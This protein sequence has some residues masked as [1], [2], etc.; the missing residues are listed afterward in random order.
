MTN[1]LDTQTTPDTGGLV[2]PSIGDSVSAVTTTAP[3]LSQSPGLV[4]GIA[5]SG[6]DTTGRAQAVARGANA[7]S[8]NNAQTRVA[9]AVGGSNELTSA[10]SWFGNHASAVGS[11]VLQGAKT[12]GSNALKILNAPLSQVQH[13]Y[14]YLHDVEAT[15]G[16]M[17]ATLEG[18]GLAAGA[19]AGL[20]ATGSL[21]GA[22]LGAETA[23]GIEGQVFYKDSW[24][25]TSSSSYVDPHT[26]QQVSLGRDIVS[27]LGSHGVH[28]EQGT[29]PYR[30]TSGIIDGLFDLNTGGTEVLGLTNEARSS[31]GLGGLLNARWGGTAPQTLGDAVNGVGVIDPSEIDRITSQYSGVRRA[32]ADIASKTPEEIIATPYL[33]PFRQ[34][35][36]QLGDAQTVDEVGQVF[37]GVLRTQELAFTDRMPSMSWTRKVFGQ[38]LR[39]QVESMT[40]TTVDQVG[41]HPLQR[42]ASLL[43]PANMAQRLSPLPTAYDDAVHALTMDSFNPASKVDDGTVGIH[44]MLRFT[45]DGPTSASTAWAYHNMPDLEQKVLAYRNISL[46]VLFALSSMRGYM[47]DDLTK[48]P[49]LEGYLRDAFSDPEDQKAMKTAIDNAFGGGMFGKEAWYGVD[50]EGRNLSSIRASEGDAQYGAAIWKNQTGKLAFLDLAEARRAASRMAGAKDVLG[51]LDDFGYHAITQGIF[52]PLVLLTPSYAMHIALAEDIPNGLREGVTAL[53][54]SK[55]AGNVARLGRRIGETEAMDADKTKAISG[56]AWH[57]VTSTMDKMPTTL[58]ADLQRRIE[59]AAVYLE[60][61]GGEAVA[62][63]L[64]SM[65]AY[66]SEVGQ[67]EKTVDLLRRSYFDSPMKSSKN[68]GLIGSTDKQAVPAWQAS[69]KEIANDESGQLAAKELI[70]GA[71]RGENIETATGNARTVLAQYLREHADDNDWAMRANSQVTSATPGFTRPP[72][73]DNYDE[74]AH[75]KLHALRGV[76]RGA[77]K[78]MNAGILAHIAEGTTP[79]R[80]ELDAIPAESRPLVIKARQMV[81]DGTGTVQ[82]IANV[83]FRRI[84]NPM[85]NFGSR[86]A[87]ALNEWDRQWEIQKPLIEAGIKD[88][89]E[90]VNTALDRT[91]NRG[92][93]NVHNL[94]D[95]TQWTVTGRNWAPFYFAQEQAYRR[96]GRLL[97]ED[98][99]AFRQYQLMISNIGNT[100]QIFQ[101]ANSKG[102]FVMPGTGWLSGS[103]SFLGALAMFKLP[104]VGS[105]P[106]GMGWNLSA[107]SVIFPLSAGARPGWGPIVAIPTQAVAQ[108]IGP[109][110]PQNLNA[111]MTAS[112]DTVL[113]PSASQSLWSNL[114]PNTILQRLLTGRVTGFDERSFDSTAMQV[115]QT[116]DFEHKIPNPQEMLNPRVAQ[117]FIDRWRNQVQVMYGAKAIVGAISPISPELQVQ[118]WGLP[119]E[120]ANDINKEG[121]LL[122]GTQVFLSKHPDA[123]PFTTWQ[124]ASNEGISIPA[125]VAAEKIINDNMGLINSPKYGNAALLL[126]IS[127]ETSATYNANVYNEQLAQGLRAKLKPFDSSGDGQFPSYLN[128]LYVAAGD[129]LVLGKWYPQYEK[130]IQGLTGTEKYQAEQNWQQTLMN[131]AALNPIWGEAFNPGG[132]FSEREAQRG[133]LINQMRALLKSPD[134]PKTKITDETRVLLNAY[135]NYQNSIKSGTQDGFVGQSQSSIDQEWKDNLYATVAAHPELTNVVTGLF[136]SLPESATTAPSATP[137]ASPGVFSTKTWNPTP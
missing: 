67:E 50:D 69:I 63:G 5:S 119:A 74:W 137:N 102:Y 80:A 134:A 59:N 130:Q 90:A 68:F 84:L 56:L 83:G 111:D 39:E 126:L 107:S 106:V 85:V 98:P 96:M 58:T 99:R 14:R 55:I 54:K 4:V 136:L 76:V 72:D 52:K 66:Q 100:G 15:H 1:T 23:G 47:A 32:F 60:A 21:Y 97:A 81:P 41:V 128:Q 123:T 64:D 121:S 17:A 19:G 79:A 122:K 108:A 26:H 133:D 110:L 124:S 35:A 10:L 88:Y 109:Y 45:E 42:A 71:K 82:K 7:I 73:W 2:A 31:E 61:T 8:S 125:S 12:M 118:N 103:A 91:V 11:D 135:D 101:G 62:P 75:V 95:R 120:L 49:D 13:E 30:L 94:S 51:R 20:V 132:N 116:L 28:L 92:L 114:V 43:N 117:T 53:V 129:A 36:Q 25:R 3:E 29:V 70:A 46:N 57:M 18:I 65:H 127:P 34:I 27:F 87:I 112:V 44:N 115:L 9:A 22:E 48:A 16:I 38:A 93:R 24:D 113:G 105:Q 104:V 40:P 131:Y 37:K 77:D 78:S 6:G 33:Q 86:Q 89:D